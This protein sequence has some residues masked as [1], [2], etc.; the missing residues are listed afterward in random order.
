MDVA[1]GSGVRARPANR[2]DRTGRTRPVSAEPLHPD[3]TARDVVRL[4]VREGLAIVVPGIAIGAIAA[5]VASRWVGSLL[6]EVSPKDPAIVSV[7][8]IT[9]LVVAIAASWIP[10]IRAARVDP[11]EALRAD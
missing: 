3:E 6:F 9:L 8:L 1:R 5:L 11:N 7:V 10:A 2:T 4:I